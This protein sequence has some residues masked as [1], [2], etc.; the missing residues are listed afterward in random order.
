MAKGYSQIEG[1]DFDDS[2]APV[3]RLESICMLLAFACSKGFMLYQM[4]VKSAFLNGNINKDVF[5][6]Q[7]LD[8]HDYMFLNHIYKLRK[9]LYGLKQ[10]LQAWYDRL[11]MFLLE[12]NFLIEKAYKILF[13]KHVNSDILIV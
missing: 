10:A 4:D 12:K 2:F 3:A 13:V 7:F 8:F 11:S 1:I 6:S 5:V 9:T